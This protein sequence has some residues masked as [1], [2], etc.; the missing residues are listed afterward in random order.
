[1]FTNF[2]ETKS[3]SA[4][5]YRGW[6]KAV[7]P[8]AAYI[9]KC[10]RIE[11][12]A[13]DCT[14]TD[15]YG[16]AYI[17]ASCDPMNLI[18]SALNS[19]GGYT[20]TGPANANDYTWTNITVGGTTGIVGPSNT[21]VINV[22]RAGTYQLYMSSTAGTNCGTTLTIAVDSGK[23]DKAS[24]TPVTTCSSNGTQFTDTSTPTSGGTVTKWAWDFNNDGKTDN[25]SKNPVYQFP[26]V[27]TYPVTLTITVGTCTAT[28]TQNVI[29]NAPSGIPVIDPAG[30]F[31]L[32]SSAV[33]LQA[34]ISGGTW[35][36][37]GIANAATGYFDPS[38]ASIGNNTIIYATNSGC[39][40]K[41][42]IIIVINAPAS[43]A[44]PNITLCSG[45]T[46]NIGVTPDANNTYIWSP[47]TGLSSPSI[48]NPTV[49]L[50][51]TGK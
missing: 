18:V 38:L 17:D 47:T 36:G 34:S 14:L 42:T 35:S 11:F 48:A 50:T 22:N 15:H 26:G 21:Q 41:D 32:N 31:C 10:V 20:L 23:L 45:N 4:I 39:P 46:A 25:T 19:C 2:K 3:G 29:V 8:L 49:T 16:Y 37:K 9:G 44:G 30:P 27:G 7:I 13:T 24:F 1:P 33:T 12:T 6:T 28:I 5:W 51:N 43:D 40:G